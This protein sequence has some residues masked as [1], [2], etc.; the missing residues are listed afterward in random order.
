MKESAGDEFKLSTVAEHKHIVWDLIFAIIFCNMLTVC[1]SNNLPLLRGGRILLAVCTSIVHVN[2]RMDS[3]AKKRW[4]A[5][6]R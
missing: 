1:T 2:M 3:K 6:Y 4:K 5:K